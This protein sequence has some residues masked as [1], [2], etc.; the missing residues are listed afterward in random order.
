MFWSHVT[1]TILIRLSIRK[2]TDLHEVW[3]ALPKMLSHQNVFLRPAN[4]VCE[5][6]V[7]TSV[8][9]SIGGR[10]SASVHAGIAD[11]PGA[12]CAVQFHAVFWNI[13]LKS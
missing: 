2:L 1:F 12:D 8:C 13:L 4:E 3:V 6:Y 7:F 9:L 5:G 11:S 10:G